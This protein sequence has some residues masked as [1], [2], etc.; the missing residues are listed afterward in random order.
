MGLCQSGYYWKKGDSRTPFFLPTHGGQRKNNNYL[1]TSKD[2]TPLSPEDEDHARYQL[3][4]DNF[5]YIYL[6]FPKS[7]PKHPKG[8]MAPEWKYKL[9]FTELFEDITSNNPTRKDFA[10][11]LNPLKEGCKHRRYESFLPSFVVYIDIDLKHEKQITDFAHDVK[12]TKEELL[13]QLKQDPK[14]FI[15]GYSKSKGIR[16]IFL[17]Y[18]QYLNSLDC[19]KDD[20]RHIQHSLYR[21]ILIYL[22]EKYGLEDHGTDSYL[23][24]CGKTITQPTFQIWQEGSYYN[25]NCQLFQ[26]DIPKVS[27]KPTLAKI[28]KG[29]IFANFSGVTYTQTD[30]IAINNLIVDYVRSL[31]ELPAKFTAMFSHYD[32]SLLPEFKY[33]AQENQQFIFELYHKHYKGNSIPTGYWGEFK[34]YLHQVKGEVLGNLKDRWQYQGIEM[35]SFR[36]KEIPTK[37]PT[38]NSTEIITD[39]SS[40]EEPT[41][42]PRKCLTPTSSQD[43][44]TFTLIPPVSQDAFNNNFTQV[45]TLT[46]NQYLQSRRTEIREIFDMNQIIVVNAGTG[47]GKSTELMYY[48]IEEVIKTVKPCLFLAPNNTILLQIYETY[49]GI[50]LIHYSG[51]C[52]LVRNYCQKDE[53][54]GTINLLPADISGPTLVLSSYESY[55]NIK[56]QQAWNVIVVDECH[57]LTSLAGISGQKDITFENCQKLIY[58]S[59]TPEISLT[60]LDNYFYLKIEVARTKKTLQI[61]PSKNFTA[62][63][64]KILRPDQKILLLQNDKQKNL[65]LAEE[66]NA[67]GFTFECLSSESKDLESHQSIIKNQLL[68]GKHYLTTSVLGEGVNLLNTQWDLIVVL[69][70]FATD[71]FSIYQFVNRMR[72]AD[73]QILYL[74]PYMHNVEIADL[75]RLLTQMKDYYC[76]S[77]ALLTDDINRWNATKQPGTQLYKHQYVFYDKHTQEYSIQYNELRKAIWSDLLK[78]LRGSKPA[79]YHFLRYFFDLE[80][81]YVK[82]TYAESEDHSSVPFLELYYQYQGELNFMWDYVQGKMDLE[83]LTLNVSPKV[84][85]LW[86]QHE[87]KWRQIMHRQ[88]EL[89]QLKTQGLNI[90][91]DKYLV[92]KKVYYDK[93][94]EKCRLNR[95]K[96]SDP[97]NNGVADNEVYTLQHRILHY[98]TDFKTKDQVD[99]SS[100]LKENNIFNPFQKKPKAFVAMLRE[101]GFKVKRSIN[102]DRR[103]IY[104]IQKTRKDLRQDPLRPKYPKQGM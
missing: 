4:H 36:K 77:V 68:T 19:N 51:Q 13:A 78:V 82:T 44:T 43:T 47:I 79:Y 24:A 86:N 59:A 70:T 71:F 72:K 104:T 12:I 25:P 37:D 48:L 64:L 60:G 20:I 8:I 62:T 39:N 58:V 102:K 18:H 52:H 61:L 69:D 103:N 14:V 32:Y 9:P 29:T 45:L 87:S 92:L 88:D 90:D 96:Y 34:Y 21:N 94:I 93:F 76:R 38:D 10:F 3:I 5:F 97:D 17:C 50:C 54:H 65:L 31:S 23:D 85:T 81:H 33:L 80:E 91:F 30:K 49:S 84:I 15:T 55:N 83:D 1:L 89:H 95:V 100:Y 73:C 46:G 74:H 40:Q 53:V 99:I 2:F 98:M 22:K 41:D 66:L 57:A 75:D 63:L 56:D 67:T 28:V 101:L 7:T 11:I 27:P 16:I 42:N 35:P 26:V 6:N